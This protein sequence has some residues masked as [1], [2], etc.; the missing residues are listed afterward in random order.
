MQEELNRIIEMAK[1]KYNV[2]E[3]QK[4]VLD[5]GYACLPLCLV[6][7]DDGSE[8]IQESDDTYDFYGLEDAH[9]YLAGNE[10]SRHDKVYHGG[11]KALI[12]LTERVD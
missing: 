5:K 10:L 1:K 4:K 3:L 9:G 2:E 8:Y 7:L 6:I 12:K 11:Y